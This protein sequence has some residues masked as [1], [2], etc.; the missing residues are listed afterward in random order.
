MAIVV[1]SNALEK[2]SEAGFPVSQ[3]QNVEILRMCVCK[4][5]FVRGREI[6]YGGG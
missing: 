5:M 1:I 6:V 2:E 3:Q 4:L